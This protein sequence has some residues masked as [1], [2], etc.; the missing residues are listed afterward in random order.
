MKMQSSF[1]FRK[2]RNLFCAFAGHVF[3]EQFYIFLEPYMSKF[4]STPVL[5]ADEKIGK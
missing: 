4:A 5:T 3:P 1:L 2:L